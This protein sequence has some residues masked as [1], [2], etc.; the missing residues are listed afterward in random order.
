[1]IDLNNPKPVHS[2]TDLVEGDKVNIIIHHRENIYGLK[3]PAVYSEIDGKAYFVER[4]LDDGAFIMT[5]SCSHDK[6]A[7]NNFGTVVFPGEYKSVKPGE[8]HYDHLKELLDI[9]EMW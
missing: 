8:E 4:F 6:L 1:M 5:H 3:R 7:F 2:I 9:N